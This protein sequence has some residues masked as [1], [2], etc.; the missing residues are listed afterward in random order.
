M[1]PTEEPRSR[2]RE[3]IFLGTGTSTCTP[4]VPCI[5]S[6]NPQCNVCKLSLTKAGAKNNRRNTSLLV[7]IDHADG[8]E[9]NI[10]ID[11]G[12]TFLV[13]AID[14]FIKH[15]VKTIDAVLLTHGHAD[16]MLGLDDLR[17]W[18]ASLKMSIPIYCDKETMDV[19]AHTFP[20]LVDTK[21]AT[22]GGGVS[23]L[24]FNVLDDLTVPFFCNDVKFQPLRVEHGKHSDGRPFYFTG[25]RF[26][27]IS[28]IS[29]VSQI[30]DET[31]PLINGSRLLVLDALKWTTH[32][33]HFSY[34]D[35]LAEVR[36]FRPERAIFTDFCHDIEH[37][38]M[39][40]H[41]KKIRAEE[42]LVVDPAYDGMVVAIM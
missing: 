10:V 24:L 35:A 33:S 41:A 15:N 42:G 8:R 39:E 37:S 31:R 25:F 34:W 27:G 9:R 40:V 36:K 13:S 11:C 30:P 17:Q 14:L 1:V 26:D 29:D 21:C 23:T 22:G 7:R 12:K 28:Y 19:V 6:D 38:A 5:T 20:Y 18:T 4:N 2:V 3:I 16:A 32:P